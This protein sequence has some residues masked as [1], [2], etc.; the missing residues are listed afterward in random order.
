LPT[1]RKKAVVALVQ[2]DTE[3]W[4]LALHPLIITNAP[5]SVPS[6]TKVGK[7]ERFQLDGDENINLDYLMR[8]GKVAIYTGA[9]DQEAL[10][11]KARIETAKKRNNPLG[12]YRQRPS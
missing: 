3:E 2:E 4:F 8:T 7:G 12:R 9:P 11:S 6:V 1:S 5:G 10:R